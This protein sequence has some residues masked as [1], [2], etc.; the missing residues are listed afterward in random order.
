MSGIQ[1]GNQTMIQHEAIELVVNGRKFHSCARTLA[2]LVEEQGLGN[3]RVATALNGEFVPE[4]RRGT[5]A[6]GAGDRVEIV[7]AR[8]GG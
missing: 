3:A 8:Q 6:L 7:S 5:T 2:E 1:F 4:A